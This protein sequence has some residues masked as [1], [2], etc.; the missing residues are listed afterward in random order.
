LCRINQG[1][2]MVYFHTKNTNLGKSG[3]HSI[4]KCW[5]IGKCW[6]ILF[7]FG[8]FYGHLVKCIGHLVYFPVLLLLFCL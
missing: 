6:F 3:A 8:I 2:Q 5:Y 7:A 1:C 4:G